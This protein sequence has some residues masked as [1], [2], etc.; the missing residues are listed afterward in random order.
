MFCKLNNVIVIWIIIFT[1]S[2][3]WLQQ[4]LTIHYSVHS[5]L[6]WR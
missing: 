6:Y 3:S 1:I 4:R 5:L 2:K